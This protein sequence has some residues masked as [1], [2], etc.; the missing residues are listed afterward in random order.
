MDTEIMRK[1]EGSGAVR[2]MPLVNTFTKMD[3][4]DKEVWFGKGTSESTIEHWQKN[5]MTDKL[6]IIN[7]YGLIAYILSFIFVFACCI[8]RFVSLE[9]LFFLILLGLSI[10]NIA[11]IWGIL[12]VF[13]VLKYI[14]KYHENN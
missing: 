4:T 9:T 8:R 3:F 1:S 14:H 6:P 7:Q 2:I 5:L 13:T 10:S 12:M 11:Y